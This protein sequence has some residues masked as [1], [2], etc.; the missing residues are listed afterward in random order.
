MRF[1]NW[2]TLLPYKKKKKVNLEI[3]FITTINSCLFRTGGGGREQAQ[4]GF[5]LRLGFGVGVCPFP[6]QR[7]RAG[8]AAGAA[9][10]AR[11]G[12]GWFFSLFFIFFFLSSSP[13]PSVT[14]GKPGCGRGRPCPGPGAHGFFSA[15]CETAQS[16][17]PELHHSSFPFP[18]SITATSPPQL[19]APPRALRSAPFPG[20]SQETPAAAAPFAF[21]LGF[22]SR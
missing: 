19:P 13:G 17:A 10:P 3:K 8:I 21:P 2:F 9:G 11:A 22:S 4:E 6:G 12:R 14:S 5:W 15:H 1:N 16:S 18:S 7:G 20:P